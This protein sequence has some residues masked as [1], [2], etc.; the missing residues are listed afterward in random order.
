MK[1]SLVFEF[2]KVVI[3]WRIGIYDLERKKS[4]FNYVSYIQ[5]PN[6]NS[7]YTGWWTL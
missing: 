2:R 3:L 5:F 6:L 7:Y 4:I 1:Q